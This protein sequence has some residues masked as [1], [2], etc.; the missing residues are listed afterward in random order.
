MTGTAEGMFSPDSDTTRGMLVTMLWRLEKEPAAKKTASFTD[1]ASGSWYDEAVAWAQE[2]GIAEG[3]GDGT[4]APNRKV[5]RE[6]L[7]AFLY[8]YAQYKGYDLTGKA[9]L[10]GFVDQPSSWAVDDVKWC[11]GNGIINGVGSN[12]LDPLGN[13]TRA[14]MAAMFHRFMDRFNV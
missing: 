1:V 7:A 10:A 2:K 9:E 5:T 3:M 13:A 14:Q 8:R 12:R 6:Q 4:F 11:V